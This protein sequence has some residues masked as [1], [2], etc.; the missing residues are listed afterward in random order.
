MTQPGVGGPGGF[1]PPPF[2]IREFGPSF[3]S[4]R[5]FANGTS[6]LPA[7]GMPPPPFGLPNMPGGGMPPHLFHL[8]QATA[9]QDYP[10]SNTSSGFH[11]IGPGGNRNMPFP[12]PFPLPN[13]ASPGPNGSAIPPPNLPF[14]PPGG[15]P[16]NFQFPPGGFPP[17]PNLQQGQG[18][19][20]GPSPL[21]GGF[22]PPGGNFPPPGNFG[23][24]APPPGLSGPPPGMG[25]GDNR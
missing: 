6:R 21:G 5:Q 23:G 2:A 3:H 9:T 17:P 10:A 13:N 15:F 14:P 1:P 12:P 19:G 4:G 25:S 7:G 16:P 11:Q 20:S 8:M 24:Q 18:P 22:P